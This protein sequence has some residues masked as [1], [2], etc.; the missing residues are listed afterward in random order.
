MSASFLFLFQSGLAA[1]ELT[2]RLPAFLAVFLP[3]LLS[4][5]LLFFAP[6]GILNVLTPASGLAALEESVGLAEREMIE[7]LAVEKEEVREGSRRRDRLGWT[8]AVERSGGSDLES[9]RRLNMI[10][11]RE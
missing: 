9:E 1:S 11:V 6:E 5:L 8:G 4:T 2:L 10:V 7:G 3:A